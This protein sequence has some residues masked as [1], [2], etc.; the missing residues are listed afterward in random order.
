MNK[1]NGQHAVEN[2]LT[3][4]MGGFMKGTLVETEE[5]WTPIDEL[6]VGD[7]VMSRPENGI[8][9]AV[10]KRVVNTFRYEDK[11]VVMLKFSC[12]PNRNGGGATL[13]ATPNYPFCV[14]GVV[15][16][17]IL[18]HPKFG[19]L[20]AYWKGCDY[21][22]GEY[23]FA[24]DEGRARYEALWAFKHTPYEMRLY[25]QPVWKRADQLERGDVVLG[26]ENDYYVVEDYRPLY[27]YRDTDQ[28][29]IQQTNL[30]YG[31]EQSELGENY[32]M[33]LNEE[34]RHRPTWDL[35]DVP[36]DENLLY[37]DED[38]QRHYRRYRTTVY[39]IEVEDYHTYCVGYQCILV[40]N[41]NCG[42][43]RRSR[44]D[45]LEIR[46]GGQP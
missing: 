44:V 25:E 24:G 17:L 18:E 13:V 12:F 37:V 20:G 46:D 28:A 2:A 10:P 11:E 36:N 16:N 41:Q 1:L 33:V 38:G 9:K 5:G 14:Y 7:L 31:W 27:A 22:D 21:D 30:A 29:W 39:N 45:S 6:K 32:N 26:L 4:G 40:H 19:K 15:T 34:S 3:S 23:V 8:G 42:A 35:M 43:E